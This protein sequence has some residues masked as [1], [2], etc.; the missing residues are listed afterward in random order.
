MTDKKST[1]NKKYGIANDALSLLI[2]LIFAIVIML[3]SIAVY[4]VAVNLTSD[5]QLPPDEQPDAPVSS[6][7]SYPFK[8]DI[9]VVVPEANDDTKTIEQDQIK[10]EFAALVDVSSGNVI[11]SRKSNSV[12]YPASMTKVMSLI[13]I[14]ENLKNESS[15]QDK[16]TITQELYNRKVSE[17]HSGD[18]KDVGEVLTVEDLIYAFAL[19]S[20]GMAGIAL[21]EYIAG[22]EYNF[23]QLMNDKANE[24]GLKN[25]NFMNCTGI[26]H[27]YHY[28]TCTDM[29]TIMMYAMINPFCAKVFSTEKYQT[30][31]SVYADGI[32]FYHAL[33]V[34]KMEATNAYPKNVDITAGKTGYTDEA[35][36]CLVSYARGNDGH[37]YILVTA[38][39]PIKNEEVIDHKTIY[40]NYIK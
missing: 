4:F 21:A 24:M 32:T 20:D 25:T 40:D 39:A 7:G 3:I 11:A 35:K 8:T 9:S 5:P 1:Q 36:Y 14:A 38:K 17:G 27:D 13:V 2:I 22:S 28:T 31:T 37:T 29:A 18:L 6:I 33:L 16:I 23:V 34:T 26:H 10:S 19:K 30:T 15:L 12:I